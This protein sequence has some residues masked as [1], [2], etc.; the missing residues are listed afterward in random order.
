MPKHNI[1]DQN[2]G[3]LV[4]TEKL[5][6]ISDEKIKGILAQ[7]YEYARRDARVVHWYDCGIAVLTNAGLLLVTLMT[8]NFHDVL[9]LNGETLQHVAWAV[10]LVL[11]VVGL[12]AAS[13]RSC[14]QSKEE[15]EERDRAVEEIWQGACK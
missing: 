6:Q 15:H 14:E 8:A 7:A 1:I 13:R 2:A 5:V 9:G 3:G 11:V 12:L 10:W 4:I